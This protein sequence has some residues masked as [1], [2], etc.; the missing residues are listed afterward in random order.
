VTVGGV[1]ASY[2]VTF[3]TGSV[4]SISE[5]NPPRI[6]GGFIRIARCVAT[7]LRLVPS[8]L[9]A[10][11]FLLNHPPATAPVKEAP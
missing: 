8:D 11:F 3:T 1:K 5:P 9:P 10:L 2:H 6:K 7:V 4:P